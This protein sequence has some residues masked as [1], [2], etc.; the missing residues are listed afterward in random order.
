MKKIR[1][2]LYVINYALSFIGEFLVAMSK[3]QKSIKE[4]TSK[5]EVKTIR[6]ETKRIRERVRK[7][8][9]EATRQN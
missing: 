7:K 9:F 4:G 1:A 3:A 8:L 6:R 5:A 2:I